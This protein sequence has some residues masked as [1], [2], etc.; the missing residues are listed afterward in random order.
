[1][2]NEAKA[3]Q[4]KEFIGNMTE[5]AIRIGLLAILV[6]WT[7][8]IGALIVGEIRCQ[9]LIIYNVV[10][11]LNRGP[12]GID[13]E[14][15]G[16]VVHVGKGVGGIMLKAEQQSAAGLLQLV[17]HLTG[18]DAVLHT[19]TVEIPYG[20]SRIQHTGDPLIAEEDEGE[21]D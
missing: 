21:D 4:R 16:V 10:Q 19:L 3:Q 7:Y 14:A 12:A 11:R 15:Q 13:M 6:I 2:D 20:I 9:D 1:M 5:S 17:E 8:D 18:P